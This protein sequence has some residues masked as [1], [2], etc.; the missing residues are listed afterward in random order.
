[1]RSILIAATAALSL[2]ACSKA[3]IAAFSAKTPA[4]KA[5]AAL[6]ITCSNYPL[7]DAAFNTVVAATPPGKIPE[8]VILAERAAVAAIGAVCSNPPADPVSALTS[9]ANAYS[10]ATRALADARK[11]SGA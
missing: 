9:A 2:A 6:D 10:A 7:V 3:D 5:Q 4:E 11:A 8:K 1:M